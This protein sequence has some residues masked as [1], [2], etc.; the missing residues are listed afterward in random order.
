MYS[1]DFRK[2]AVRLYKKYKNYRKVAS[3]LHISTSTI[4]R[5]NTKGI[6]TKK[7][8]RKSRV[9][10]K[11]KDFIVDFI[12]KKPFITQWEISN[13]IHDHLNLKI[14]LK[15]ISRILKKLSFTKKKA[16]TLSN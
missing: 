3:L 4:H 10:D 16:Y 9:F 13:E 7:T 11:V 2:L 14:S 5:W 12:E 15:T 8:T 1:N 6:G